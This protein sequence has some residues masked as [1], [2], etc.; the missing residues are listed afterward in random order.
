MYCRKKPVLNAMA[1]QVISLG[2]ST[3]RDKT[4]VGFTRDNYSP[5]C[6]ELLGPHLF[7]LAKAEILTKEKL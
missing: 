2:L 1:S 5:E 7:D 3:K 6:I 4:I